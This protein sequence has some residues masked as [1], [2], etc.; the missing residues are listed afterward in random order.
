M[1]EAAK[2]GKS[3]EELNE[4]ALGEIRQTK[5]YTWERRLQGLPPLLETAAAEADVRGEGTT[6][7]Q[8]ADS[9]I[10]FGHML[11]IYDPVELA[12]VYPQLAYL[13]LSS[14]QTAKRITTAAGYHIP[15]SGTMDVDPIEEMV[16]QVG[17]ER[18]GVFNTK[19]GTWLREMALRALPPMRHTIM[20]RSQQLAYQQKMEIETKL[21]LVDSKGKPTWFTAPGGKPNELDMLT[22]VY[23]HAKN[24][25]PVDRT[26]A[27]QFL[28]GKQGGGA[29]GVLTDPRVLS[30]LA[31]M[32]EEA[33]GYKPGV[34]YFKY[35]YENSPGQQVSQAWV[36]MQNVLVDIGQVALPFAIGGL[37]S[38]S[39]SLKI[40]RAAW[41]AQGEFG[42]APKPGPWGDF[43]TA[44]GKGMADWWA[45]GFVAG[46][47]FGAATTTPAGGIG[48]VPGAILG[49]AITAVGGGIYEGGKYLL[50]GGLSLNP[51]SPAGA[52]ESPWLTAPAPPLSFADRAAGAQ[53][54]AAAPAAAWPSKQSQ[55][56]IAPPVIPYNFTFKLDGDL[57]VNKEGI[58]HE[59]ASMIARMLAK[60]TEH[61]QGQG[62]G[63]LSSPYTSGAVF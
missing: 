61:N 25:S 47:I 12:K 5:G 7:R 4:A 30:Q 35:M 56:V 63:A 13:A 44:V 28:F 19:S 42:G 11:K 21:G 15:V 55:P 2:T 18:S 3:Y 50:G 48:I 36:A 39:E 20:S 14:P 62:D 37:R 26:Q 22:K 27:E 6:V 33:K 52:A 43:T 41:P 29:V 54:P 49:G 46:G 16:L 1:A 40:L 31:I 32:K 60:A 17:L 45:P 9:L 10:A 57:S 58:V 24:M 53:W 59:I 8:T 34:E 23:E 38:V 51:I